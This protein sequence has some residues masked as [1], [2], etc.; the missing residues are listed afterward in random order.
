MRITAIL[1]CH[2]RREK[3]LA[4][5]RSY[6]DQRIPDSFALDA[7]LVDDGSSD[8]TVEAVRALGKPVV[9]IRGAGDLYWAAGMALAEE[10]AKQSS[11]DYL[12]WLNDDGVLDLDALARLVAVERSYKRKCIVIGALRDPDNGELTYSG[13]RRHR[14]HPL[15]FDRI[16]PERQPVAVDTFE[17]NVVL[18]PRAVA[19][20]VG[21]ID[22]QFAHAAA[23]WDYGLRARKA[24][25]VNLLAPGTVGSCPYDHS[26]A[27]WLEPSLPLRERRELLFGR[28]GVPP[29][30]RARFL[31]RHGGLLWPVFWA[32]P[33]AR[34]ALS[35][36]RP[37]LLRRPK[38]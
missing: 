36:V 24:G 4:C 29:R 5:L 15:R 11:P 23:D 34:F 2:N 31:K 3:S 17:G 16:P 33:Y 10:R 20:S 27:P 14:F 13:I 35:L 32:S 8:G 21:H 1:T 7:V 30:S 37:A 22:G 28:K 12:L 38:R 9:I 25:V 18:V 19:L 26:F 6:F